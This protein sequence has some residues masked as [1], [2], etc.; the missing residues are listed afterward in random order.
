MSEPRYT[1]FG[2]VHAFAQGFALT[3]EDCGCVVTDEKAH[4]RFHSILGGHA[5]ALAVL[6]VA[7]IAAHVHDKYDT[8]DRIAAT[9]NWSAEALAEVIAAHDEHADPEAHS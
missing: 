1:P 5:H 9:D 7:H 4:T 6:Q 8:Y 3:C 2:P